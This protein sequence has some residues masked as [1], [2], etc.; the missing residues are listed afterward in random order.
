MALRSPFAIFAFDISAM[1]RFPVIILVLGFLAFL[2]C[3]KEDDHSLASQWAQ[4]SQNYIARNRLDSAVLLNFKI[5]ESIDTT[6]RDN[7]DIIASTYNELGEI[8]YKATIFDRAMEM[9]EHSLYYG[10]RL[11]DKTEE[12]RARRGIWRCSHGLDLPEKDTAIAHS[13]N[14]L[15]YIGSEKEI[16]S[17]YNNITGY[18]MYKGQY[19]SA[20]V[21]NRI[22][23][24]KSSDSATLYRNYGIRSALFIY[25]ENYDSAWHYASIASHSDDIYTKATSVYRLSRI[26]EKKRNDSSVFYLKYYNELLDSIHNIK[27]ADSI[28]VVLY[29]KQL[30]AVQD[31][32]ERDRAITAALAL[33]LLLLVCCIAIFF[34]KI[35]R[36]NSLMNHEAE[37]LKRKLWELNVHL[38]EN[39]KKADKYRQYSE[40]YQELLIR[41]KSIEDTLVAQLVADRTKCIDAFKRSAF[42]KK[43]PALI[44]NG[45]AI[46]RVDK[47]EEMQK[48]IDKDF[49]LLHHSL[50]T[51]FDISEE[52]F[53]LYCLSVAGFSTKECAACRGVSVSA[54]RMQRMRMN[55]KI[56]SFFSSDIDLSD[57]LL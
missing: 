26:A 41:Q 38:A 53:V 45:D 17:L 32:A 9:Y 48:A 1:Q 28:N 20:F 37:E 21:Y 5:L 15:P 7:F 54:I 6:S 56:K 14:L 19:D 36:K 40:R 44:E 31:T 34:V 57:I 18:F 22:A 55:N 12:S 3:R 30:A 2:S 13:L 27:S 49:M 4:E 11:E 50:A 25:T 23:I 47:R 39:K 46:L 43:L 24:E 29:R 8:F 10:S 35:R 52:E 51:Y 33:A 42:Y 16:A